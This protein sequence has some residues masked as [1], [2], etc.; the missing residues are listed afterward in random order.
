MPN[1]SMSRVP[2]ATA[3]PRYILHKVPKKREELRPHNSQGNG[4]TLVADEDIITESD[5]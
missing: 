5:S 3:P 4:A 1:K 2:E